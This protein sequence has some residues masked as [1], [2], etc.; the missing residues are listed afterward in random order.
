MISA[1]ITGCSQEASSII[2]R[3]PYWSSI[4]TSDV[5]EKYDIITETTNM[6]NFH[7][8]FADMNAALESKQPS[9]PRF[10]LLKLF[11]AHGSSKR[12][13]PAGSRQNDA[14]SR[15]RSRSRARERAASGGSGDSYDRHATCDAV[16]RH[17]DA[18]LEIHHRQQELRDLALHL[19]HGGA[20][21]GGAVPHPPYYRH[22]A[23]DP[24][25]DRMAA[26][27]LPRVRTGKYGMPRLP[28]G[29][30]SE[31][32]LPFL[33]CALASIALQR[34]AEEQAE[35]ARALAEAAES[36]SINASQRAGPQSEDLGDT[37]DREDS[38]ME[39]LESYVPPNAASGK[40][41][42]DQRLKRRTRGGSL[43]APEHESPEHPRL[44]QSRSASRLG[45]MQRLRS[46]TPSLRSSDSYASSIV[47]RRN[48]DSLG[49]GQEEEENAVAGDAASH[50]SS[51]ETSITEPTSEVPRH[52]KSKKDGKSKDKRQKQ[53]PATSPQ[54]H[55]KRSPFG[56]FRGSDHG[57][58]QAQNQASNGPRRSNDSAPPLLPQFPRRESGPSRLGFRNLASKLVPR[59]DSVLRPS[60]APKRHSDELKTPLLL[61][62]QEQDAA[63]LAFAAPHMERSASAQQPQT[64]PLHPDA[65]NGVLSAAE[66]G[67]AL[68]PKPHAYRR[69]GLPSHSTEPLLHRSQ[70]QPAS[71]PTSPAAKAKRLSLLALSSLGGHAPQTAYIDE[72]SADRVRGRVDSQEDV[73]E[74]EELDGLPREEASKA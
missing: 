32:K 3:H 9:K 25:S 27:A 36:A 53:I 70:R 17:M 35:E 40:V 54:P 10:P 67:P 13:T 33:D 29:S 73:E 49:H 50:M 14:Q 20:S 4:P 37:S 72:C 41:Q 30:L 28:R 8:A 65:S 23:V 58:A 62:Q 5:P 60:A 59:K 26:A 44:E 46:R 16:R 6:E 68:P 71:R 1:P 21:Y 66:A 55:A 38:D 15:S 7:I 34:Q 57:H 24:I 18:E 51:Q 74:D 61:S 12:S 47:G 19:H 31:E 48:Q 39:M 22:R 56:I 42:A 11:G 64:L 52:A 2:N 63:S 45:F 69:P 43:Y